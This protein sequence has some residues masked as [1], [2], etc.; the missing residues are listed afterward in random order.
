MVGLTL[1][2]CLGRCTRRGRASA[3]AEGRLERLQEYQHLAARL[4]PVVVLAEIP[5]EMVTLGANT[6]STI[7]CVSRT[8]TYASV[9]GSWVQSHAIAESVIVRRSLGR[10]KGPRP[11]GLSQDREMVRR[12]ARIDGD[13]E[14]MPGLRVGEL[15]AVRC[16]ASTGGVGCGKRRW[17]RSGARRVRGRARAQQ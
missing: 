15:P 4:Q 8:L 11:F 16:R 6:C 5:A 9:A 3:S 14:V 13:R 10:Q 17:T 12:H 1:I 7:P 2:T